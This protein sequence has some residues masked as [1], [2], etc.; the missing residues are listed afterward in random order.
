MEDSKLFEKIRDDMMHTRQ[1]RFQ[2]Q[3]GKIAAIGAFVGVGSAA[4]GKSYLLFYL[5]PFVAVAFDFFILGESFTLRRMAAF[6]RNEKAGTGQTEHKWEEFVRE[7]PDYLSSMAN[8]LLTF[9]SSLAALSIL[10]FS[11]SIPLDWFKHGPNSVWLLLVF[12][13][14][15]SSKIIEQ[16]HFRRHWRRPGVDA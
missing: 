2:Y 1:R 12:L 9:A 6:I 16:S 15:T 13:A 7:N 5:V 8:F 10:V 3:L 11:E 14:I 4:G